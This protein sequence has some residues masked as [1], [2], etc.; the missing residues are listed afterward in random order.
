LR[1]APAESFDSPGLSF[2]Q[3][4]FAEIVDT[5][6]TNR[7]RVVLRQQGRF[8]EGNKMTELPKHKMVRISEPGMTPVYEY[9]GFK[10]VKDGQGWFY[11]TGRDRWTSLLTSVR[12]FIDHAIEKEGVTP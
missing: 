9:R 2:A 5:R 3:K 1:E 11:Y 4:F 8:R 12:F 6:I 7:V 10:I